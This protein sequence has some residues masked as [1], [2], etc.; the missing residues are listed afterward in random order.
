MD[1]GVH[2]KSLMRGWPGR[3]YYPC[4]ATLVGTVELLHVNVRRLVT[5][6][7]LLGSQMSC[8]GHASARACALL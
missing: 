2:G 6:P 4:V 7:A 5:G 3:S 8:L 1:H